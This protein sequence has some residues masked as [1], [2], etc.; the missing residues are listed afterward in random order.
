[1]V[2]NVHVKFNHDRLR[3]GKALGTFRRSDNNKDKN[4]PVADVISTPFYPVA[5]TGESLNN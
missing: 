1:M 3:I 4:N 2:T 5:P